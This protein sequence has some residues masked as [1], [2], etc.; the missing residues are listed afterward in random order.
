MDTTGNKQSNN[1]SKVTLLLLF[2]WLGPYLTT[3]SAVLITPLNEYVLLSQGNICVIRASGK[4]EEGEIE[5]I[6][7]WKNL[8][9]KRYVAGIVTNSIFSVLMIHIG[10]TTKRSTTWPFPL[11]HNRFIE[12]ARLVSVNDVRN[13]YNARK[14]C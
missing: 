7:V 10:K 12:E 8:S 3:Y 4:D 14:S 5:I 11:L 1:S 2:D 6:E 9:R 13:L